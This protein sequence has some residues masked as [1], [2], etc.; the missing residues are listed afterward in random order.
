MK[1]Y[2]DILIPRNNLQFDNSINNLLKSIKLDKL[3]CNVVNAKY[4]SS[5]LP[6]FTK[7]QYL[8]FNI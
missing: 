6:S 4:A 3:T 2:Q 8:S 5:G 1:D 7:A